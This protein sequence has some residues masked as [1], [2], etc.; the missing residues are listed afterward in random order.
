MKLLKTVLHVFN[1]LPIVFNT[2]KLHDKNSFYFFI[3]KGPIP[4]E[5]DPFGFELY[6]SLPVD[7]TLVIVV[8]QG[9]VIPFSVNLDEPHT[10]INILGIFEA[11]SPFDHLKLRINPPIAV[12]YSLQ[13]SSDLTNRSMIA[14]GE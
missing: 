12:N 3:K 4:D 1:D 7:P 6:F 2:F 8:R 9:K 5:I 10:R 14:L 13:F 11:I